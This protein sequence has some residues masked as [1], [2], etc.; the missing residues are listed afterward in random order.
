MDEEVHMR[1]LAPLLG[2]AAGSSTP[3]QPIPTPV[4]STKATVSLDTSNIPSQS[5]SNS[6]S[7]RSSLIGLTFGTGSS[8]TSAIPNLSLS[9]P[10]SSR[11]QSGSSSLA[12]GSPPSGASTVTGVSPSPAGRAVPIASKIEEKGDAGFAVHFGDRNLVF[13]V[14]SPTTALGWREQLKEAMETR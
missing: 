13:I 7:K 8:I 6:P 1:T 5:G 10:G 9:L 4:D 2:S 11:T 3:S 12:V 14:D